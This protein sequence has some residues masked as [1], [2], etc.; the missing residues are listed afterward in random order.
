MRKGKSPAL[1]PRVLPWV[2]PQSTNTTP[3]STGRVKGPLTHSKRPSSVYAQGSSQNPISLTSPSPPESGNDEAATSSGKRR[4]TAKKLPVLAPQPPLGLHAAG[5]HPTDFSAEYFNLADLE[6]DNALA[7]EVVDLTQ[8]DDKEESV[9]VG[10][11]AVNAVGVRYYSGVATLGEQVLLQRDPHNQASLGLCKAF[12][13][14]TNG[15]PST[16][17]MPFRF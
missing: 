6:G 12:V 14:S 9:W 16:I 2:P 4:K 17:A 3:T 11:F 15:P 1:A 7:Q 5:L 10:S 8:S 13:M